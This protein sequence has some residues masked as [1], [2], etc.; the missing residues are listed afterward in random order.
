MFWQIPTGDK[1]IPIFCGA[2]I[3]LSHSVRTFLTFFCVPRSKV[4]IQHDVDE[5][6]ER[7]G[8]YFIR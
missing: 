3:Y 8:C 4:I 5:N 6:E 1:C 7:K 2:V